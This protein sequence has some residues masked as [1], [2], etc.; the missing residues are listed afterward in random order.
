MLDRKQ[1]RQQIEKIERIRGELILAKYRYEEAMADFDNV[2]RAGLSTNKRRSHSAFTGFI[3]KMNPH[4]KL[5]ILSRKNYMIFYVKTGDEWH[6]L[7]LKKYT[8]QK[9]A[10]SRDEQ[11]RKNNITPFTRHNETRWTATR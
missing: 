2:F 10:E 11:A 7:V 5:W 9:K 3:K 6:K 4:M 8:R 1:L